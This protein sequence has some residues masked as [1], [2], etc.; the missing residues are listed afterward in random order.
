MCSVKQELYTSAVSLSN[1]KE[2][3]LLIIFK[4]EE[5]EVLSINFSIKEILF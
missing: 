4:K 2:V 1:V 3:C 5:E